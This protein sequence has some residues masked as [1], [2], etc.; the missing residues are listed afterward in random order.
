MLPWKDYD[1]QRNMLALLLYVYRTLWMIMKFVKKGQDPQT[2]YKPRHESKVWGFEPP[3]GRDILC[4]RNFHK[5]IR[6]CV[7]NEC[8]CPSPVSI[9]NDNFT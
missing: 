7:E 8:C 9:S 1:T 3:S 5:S 2:I 6:S 4:P